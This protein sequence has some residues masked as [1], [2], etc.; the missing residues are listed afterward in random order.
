MG[1]NLG[2]GS[3]CVIVNFH[4]DN[5]CHEET[6]FRQIDYLP[7]VSRIV[8]SEF[9]EEVFLEHIRKSNRSRDCYLWTNVS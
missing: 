1:F 4:S 3:S 7:L 2:C 6:E 5:Q 9:N 8:Q